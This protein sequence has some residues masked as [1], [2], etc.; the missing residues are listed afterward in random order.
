MPDGRQRVVVAFSGA[1]WAYRTHHFLELESQG[2]VYWREYRGA[3][4]VYLFSKRLYAE[5]DSIE[6]HLI[7]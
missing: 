6:F 5:I 7:A 1:S 3:G 2:H 4:S